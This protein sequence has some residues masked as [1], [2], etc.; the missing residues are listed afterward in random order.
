MKTPPAFPRLPRQLALL[1]LLVALPVLSLLR[2]ADDRVIAAVRAADDER[3]AATKSGERARLDVIYSDEL[4]YAHSSGKI[5]TKAS[6]VDAL[7]SRRSVYARYDY[8]KREFRQIA[9]G[10]VLMTGRVLIEAGAAGKAQ[11]NDLNFLGVWR[12]EK[13]RWRFVAWQSCK[14]PDPAAKK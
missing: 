11:P 4:H 12:E 2:A 14:N 13:G 1:G 3:V 5:D 7:V 6:Y 8:Q 9:P 10:V